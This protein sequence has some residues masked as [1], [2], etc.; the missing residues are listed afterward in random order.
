MERG[1]T[2]AA[3]GV[4]RLDGQS[5]GMVHGRVGFHSGASAGRTTGGGGDPESLRAGEDGA[6]GPGES[7]PAGDAIGPANPDRATDR[8][9]PIRARGKVARRSGERTLIEP[10][11]RAGTALAFE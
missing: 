2:A 9:E 8:P 7:A 11:M 1:K 3:V 5:G 4:V 10:A 6:G